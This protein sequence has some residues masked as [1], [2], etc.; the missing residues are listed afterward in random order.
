MDELAKCGR[1]KNARAL[2]NQRGKLVA[3]NM[4]RAGMDKI[5]SGPQ[6]QNVEFPLKAVLTSFMMLILST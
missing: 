2:K 4:L 3:E 6:R 1:L 5:Y